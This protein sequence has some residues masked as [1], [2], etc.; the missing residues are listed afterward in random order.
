MEKGG[1]GGGV[2]AQSCPTLVT[3]W[4]VTARLLGPRDFPGKNTRVGCLHSRKIPLQGIFKTQ[5]SNLGLPHCRWILYH[6]RHQGS[7]RILE[8]IAKPSSR[9]S[10]QPKDRTHVSCGIAGGFFTA[11]PVKPTISRTLLQWPFLPQ[12]V[13]WTSKLF[14]QSSKPKHGLL[15]Q[16]V[17]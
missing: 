2:V 16:S 4:T 13:S 10:S 7:S 9:G 11:E 12:F 15:Q 1:G 14:V 17:L 3:K 6:L 8:W 5:G